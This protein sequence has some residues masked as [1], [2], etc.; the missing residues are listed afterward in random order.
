LCLPTNLIPI[1][2]ELALSHKLWEAHTNR[3]RLLWQ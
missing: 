2:A 1:N 3:A